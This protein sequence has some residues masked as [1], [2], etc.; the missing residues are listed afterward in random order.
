MPGLSGVE[1][2][3]AAQAWDATIGARFVLMT[4]GSFG[5]GTDALLERVGVR[6]LDKPFEAQDVRALVQDMVGAPNRSRSG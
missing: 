1:V 3:Q 4:G 5:A 2:L 6:T